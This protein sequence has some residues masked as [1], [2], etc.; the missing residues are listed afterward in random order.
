M[1]FLLFLLLFSHFYLGIVSCYYWKQLKSDSCRIKTEWG[2]VLIKHKALYS[3]EHLLELNKTWSCV[4]LLTRQQDAITTHITA[5]FWSN[6]TSIHHL[7]GVEPSKLFVILASIP[8]ALSAFHSLTI[9]KALSFLNDILKGGKSSFFIWLY[10]FLLLIF[11]TPAQAV[12][13]LQ[14]HIACSTNKEKKVQILVPSHTAWDLKL[15]LPHSKKVF[16]LL[17]LLG[18][19]YMTLIW[20]SFWFSSQF[21]LQNHFNTVSA[22]SVHSNTSRLRDWY[23]QRE[24]IILSKKLLSWQMSMVR[25]AVAFNAPNSTQYWTPLSWTK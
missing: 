21:A 20:T 17:G 1:D 8:W 16:R 5:T 6:R 14:N 22:K 4:M 18:Y 15:H 10:N 3:T 2:L 23:L 11:G 19:F 9:L 12:H 24:K 13:K 7:S 25:R